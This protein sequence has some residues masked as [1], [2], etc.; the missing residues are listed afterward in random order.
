MTN[1]IGCPRVT[2]WIASKISTSRD[3]ALS[4]SLSLIELNLWYKIN[5]QPTP[6]LLPFTLYQNKHPILLT[7]Q[8]APS[9]PNS[10]THSLPP[11]RFQI[12]NPLSLIPW[13]LTTHTLIATLITLRWFSRKISTEENK[14]NLVL[15]WLFPIF[16]RIGW[17]GFIGLCS[18]PP[19]SSSSSSSSSSVS[20]L[21][22]TLA[23]VTLI[24]F[25]G[26]FLRFHCPIFHG[27]SNF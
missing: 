13:S 6:P 16:R 10:L 2:S 1:S 14:K 20:F 27:F 17:L 7:S 24:R 22:S 11:T 18:P 9:N 4:L 21:F 19:H 25:T 15:C 26:K 23:P 8:L 3:S 5:N 12:R